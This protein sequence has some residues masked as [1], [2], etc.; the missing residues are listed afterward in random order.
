[1]GDEHPLRI[2]SEL[3]RAGRI[4]EAISCLEAA[5]ERARSMAERPANTS[6]LARTAGL[7]CEEAGRLPRAVRYYEEALA[8]AVESEPLLL[9]ALAEVHRRSGQVARAQVCLDEAEAL[10]RGSAEV[11][12]ALRVA[13]LREAWARDER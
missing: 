13:Q 3:A 7:L 11:D 2:A 9:L 1:M 5:L 12:V 10:A 6:L 4:D 8:V